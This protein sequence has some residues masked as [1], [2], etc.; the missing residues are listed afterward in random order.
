MLKAHRAG[1]SA[2]ITFERWTTEAR[3][4]KAGSGSEIALLTLVTN[5]SNG[6]RKKCL[7]NLIVAHK[8]APR[9]TTEGHCKDEEGTENGDETF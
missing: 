6:S 3:D 2:L 7:E 8:K 9:E 4:R 5:F 1:L